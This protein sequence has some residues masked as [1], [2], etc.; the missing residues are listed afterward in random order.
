[1][2]PELFAQSIP[3]QLKYFFTALKDGFQWKNEDNPVLGNRD[4]STADIFMKIVRKG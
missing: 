1:V 3:Y 4:S 2:I